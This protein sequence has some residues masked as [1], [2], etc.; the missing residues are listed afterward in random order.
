MRSCKNNLFQTAYTGASICACDNHAF[1]PASHLDAQEHQP[2]CQCFSEGSGKGNDS[3]RQAR[4]NQRDCRAMQK[5]DL[6]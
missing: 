1:P 3:I 2:G 4:M 6:N 5:G